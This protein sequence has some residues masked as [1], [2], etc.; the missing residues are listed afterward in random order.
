MQLCLF[1]IDLKKPFDSVETEAVTEASS[2]RSS[3]PFSINKD[4]FATLK[5]AMRGL[6]WDNVG[7]EVDC[8]DLHHLRFADD[9][10]LITSSIN[11]GNTYEKLTTRWIKTSKEISRF[12]A[13][14]FKINL[15]SLTAGM[16]NKCFKL[17]LNGCL[18]LDVSNK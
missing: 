12:F 11:Q 10:V 18:S 7:V 9:I 5:I 8:R 1:S 6:E 2:W 4:T 14:S 13:I 3:R 16:L 15:T 17:A